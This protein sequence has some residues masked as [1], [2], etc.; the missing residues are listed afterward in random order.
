MQSSDAIGRR[1][2]FSAVPSPSR[3]TYADFMR[4][5]SYDPSVPIWMK[6]NDEVRRRIFNGMIIARARM[7]RVNTPHVRSWNS[8]CLHSS[9]L[10]FS[11]ERAHGR[12]PL[13]ARICQ[14]V[15]SILR[16][17]CDFSWES[18]RSREERRE[19]RTAR[20]SSIKVSHKAASAI[21]ASLTQNYENY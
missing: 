19:P 6:V 15:Q 2:I 8:L 18:P 4:A 21:E 10:I 7:S 11:V 3:P 1:R 9:W 17:R 13:R 5:T 12:R 16:R 14:Q 20:E